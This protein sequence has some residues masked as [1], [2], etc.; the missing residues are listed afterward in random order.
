MALV[1]KYQSRVLNEKAYLKE[2]DKFFQMF[3]NSL[4]RSYQRQDSMIVKDDDT[5]YIDHYKH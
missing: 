5:F 1:V 4:N 3:T 2:I